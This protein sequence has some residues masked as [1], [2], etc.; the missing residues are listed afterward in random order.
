MVQNREDHKNYIWDNLSFIIPSL[1]QSLIQIV[2]SN[3]VMVTNDFKVRFS[4]VQDFSEDCKSTNKGF[5][6]GNYSSKLFAENLPQRL[7]KV[8]QQ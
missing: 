2:V 5:S 8:Y 1:S 6:T 7:P 3:R 4:D